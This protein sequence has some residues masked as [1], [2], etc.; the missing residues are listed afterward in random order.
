MSE[1]KT[2]IYATMFID[3]SADVLPS[4]ICERARGS[5]Y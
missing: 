2:S 5:F 1:N 3:Y 4:F